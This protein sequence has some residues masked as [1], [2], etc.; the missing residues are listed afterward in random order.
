LLDADGS[1]ATAYAGDGFPPVAL[2]AYFDQAPAVKV[3]LEHGPDV[4]ARARNTM[5]VQPIHAAVAGRST[6]AVRLLL[7]S[8]A[9]ANARQHGGWTPLHAAA[10]HGHVQ[11]VDLLLDAG[12]DPA[13]ANDEGRTAATLADQN[14]HV[15]LAARL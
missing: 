12:A 1:L 13:A 3:L 2:A 8:G 15:A 5:E 6:G 11:I 10:A 14:G 4:H 7:E 9:D